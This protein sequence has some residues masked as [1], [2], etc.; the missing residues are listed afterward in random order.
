MDHASE[1][2]TPRW[3]GVLS[4]AVFLA[5]LFL[6]TG[7][8]PAGVAG[9]VDVSFLPWLNA[10]L[11]AT[12]ATL[13][14]AAFAAIKAKRVQLHKTLMTTALGASATFLVSYVVYHWFSAGPTHYEGPFRAG[15]LVVLISHVVLATIIL[16]AALTTWYRGWTGRVAAHRSIAPW[17]FGLW[18]YVAVTGVLITVLAH[19]WP[20]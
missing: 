10:A 2:A 20:G 14:L 13:L 1:R 3:V 5:V 15:Y 8:R 7:P 12:T 19:R 16:P 17:T 11:N 9:S 4:G 18:L 6:L